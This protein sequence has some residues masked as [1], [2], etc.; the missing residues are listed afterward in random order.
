[1]TQPL[2]ML[3]V[4]VNI[5]NVSSQSESSYINKSLYILSAQTITELCGRSYS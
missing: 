2:L 4:L 5:N 1:M 3:I